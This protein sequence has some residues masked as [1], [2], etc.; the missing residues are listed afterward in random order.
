[1][2]FTVVSGSH[3]SNSQSAK[4]AAYIEKE[5][6]YLEDSY[7]VFKFELANNP[8]PMWDE[9]VWNDGEI[10]A[11]HWSPIAK[12]LQ[13]SDAFVFV[14]P[15]W[16]GM[17]PPGFKNFMLLCG[18]EEL[19]HKPALLVSVS[20]SRNGAYPIAEMRMTSS[21]NNHVVY[22]P[23]HVIVRD[24]EKM[25][26]SDS[27]NSDDDKYLRGRMSYSLKML[28][29]YGEALKKIR[30]SGIVDYKSFPNGM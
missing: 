2:K 10:W 24:A 9:S 5:L 25:L 21:K 12:E 13:D 19:G 3:R 18:N 8:L 30:S 11:E 20:G 23:D 4:V 29:E 16:A 15:E 14:V 27:P 6:K 28:C 26:N 7:S 1:M 17:V 22:V